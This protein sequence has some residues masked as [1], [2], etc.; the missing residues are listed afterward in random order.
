MRTFRRFLGVAMAAAVAAVG[1]MAAPPAQAAPRQ[2]IT[3]FD[4]PDEVATKLLSAGITMQAVSPAL[5]GLVSPANPVTGQAAGIRVVLPARPAKAGFPIRHRGGFWF[6]NASAGRG[7]G[8]L[9]PTVVAGESATK[10]TVTCAITGTGTSFDGRRVPVLQLSDV[11]RTTGKQRMSADVSLA[12]APDVAPVLNDLLGTDAF[13]SG[14][15]LGTASVFTKIE[16]TW[17][18]GG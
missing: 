15:A 5:T 18:E 13:V 8:C 2:F 7:V 11:R 10:A 4:F 16:W 17:E 6:T 9:A 14:M 3:E 1:L 12:T